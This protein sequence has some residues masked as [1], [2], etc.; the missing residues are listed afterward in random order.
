M[1]TSNLLQADMKAPV[2]VNRM[3]ESKPNRVPPRRFAELA[4]NLSSKISV[5]ATEP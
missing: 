1:E 2:V 4:K 3:P 5:T